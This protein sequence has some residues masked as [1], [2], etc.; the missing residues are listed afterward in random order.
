M[1]LIGVG[2]IWWTTCIGHALHNTFP[3]YPCKGKKSGI[4]R[5]WEEIFFESLVEHFE[6]LRNDATPIATRFARER[7]GETTTRDDNEKL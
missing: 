4:K 7:T 3:K 2:K 1:E 6:E 5:Q